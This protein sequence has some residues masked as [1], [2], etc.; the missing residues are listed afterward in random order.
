MPCAMSSTR[1]RMKA[2]I[3][4]S[5]SS[6]SVWTSATSRSWSTSMTSPGAL[7]PIRTITRRPD[8]MLDFAREHSGPDRGDQDLSF[9]RI[10]GANDLELP[11]CD[12]EE[13][14]VAVARLDEHL[15]GLD[16]AGPPERGHPSDL[17]R[18]ERR[19]HLLESLRGKPGNGGG[20]G[21]VGHRSVSGAENTPRFA[22][23]RGKFHI[24]AREGELESAGPKNE[25]HGRH[26]GGV[27]IRAIERDRRRSPH[28]ASS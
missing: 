28:R 11:A 4:I 21:C 5:P 8:S 6:A 22:D 14:N 19:K 12:D 15:A 17:R 16:V 1:R 13:G 20:P 10:R 18:R 25:R 24:A 27:P 26:L 7:A 23:L 9:V 2:R 3:R